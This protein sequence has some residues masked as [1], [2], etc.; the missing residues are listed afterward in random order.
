MFVWRR[1]GNQCLDTAPATLNMSCCVPCRSSENPRPFSRPTTTHKNLKV[2]SS[3][4]LR[5][6]EHLY[7]PTHTALC[8]YRIMVLTRPNI[9]VNYML[10]KRQ[11]H[12]WENLASSAIRQ[13]Q[14]YTPHTASVWIFNTA[15]S[16]T[17]FVWPRRPIWLLTSVFQFT[18]CHHR[19]AL[20]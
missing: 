6:F 9:H 15:R 16:L 19:P 8:V 1:T 12:E 17:K 7:G 5:V 18:I 3:A 14:P 13:F 4:Y 20:G 10:G 11:R 2:V